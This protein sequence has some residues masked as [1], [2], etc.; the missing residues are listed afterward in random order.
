[1]IDGYAANYVLHGNNS[2][3]ESF[4][5]SSFY[6]AAVICDKHVRACVLSTQLSDFNVFK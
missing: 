1:M 4:E 2:A 5:G 6:H 3:L